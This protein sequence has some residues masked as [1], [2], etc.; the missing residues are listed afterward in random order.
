MRRSVGGTELGPVLRRLVLLRCL[1]LVCSEHSDVVLVRKD[2]RP[3]LVSTA[4]ALLRGV[5]FAGSSG[6]LRREACPS[7]ALVGSLASAPNRIALEV[8]EKTT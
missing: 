2:A 5:L 3:L 4:L 8:S 1:A 7:R 6:L